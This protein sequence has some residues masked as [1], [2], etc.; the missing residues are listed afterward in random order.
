VRKTVL[1]VVVAVLAG[2]GAVGALGGEGA[3]QPDVPIFGRSTR[4]PTAAA[5]TCECPLSPRQPSLNQA[6][7]GMVESASEFIPAPFDPGAALDGNDL[8]D[9]A[10]HATLNDYPNWFV[11]SLSS[12]MDL[13]DVVIRWVD[14]TLYGK[15]FEVWAYQDVGA[16]FAWVRVLQEVNWDPAGSPFYIRRFP[17]PYQRV[18]KLKFVLT[19]AAGQART[20]MRRFAWN[21]LQEFGATPTWSSSFFGAPWDVLAALDGQNDLSD[22]A[23]HYSLNSYPNWFQLTLREKTELRSVQVHWYSSSYY[24]RNFRVLAFRGGAWTTVALET[25]WSPPDASAVYNRVLAAPLADVEALSLVVLEAVGQPRMLLRQ[26]SWNRPL[27]KTVRYNTL[28][29]YVHAEYPVVIKDGTVYKMWYSGLSAVDG[30]WRI[31]YAV[32][33]D[34]VAWQK[35]GIVLDLGAGNAWDSSTVAFPFVV[36][37]V[38]GQYH[39]WYAGAKIGNAYEIGY[40]SSADGIHWIKSSSNPVISLLSLGARL[41]VDPSVVY[42]PGGGSGQFQVWLNVY[43]ATGGGHVYHAT[44]NDGVTW[45]PPVAT[46]AS[47]AVAPYTVDVKRETNG[48]YTMYYAA[49]ADRVDIYRT[50]SADGITWGAS[51]PVLQAPSGDPAQWDSYADYGMSVLNDGGQRRMWFNGVPLAERCDGGVFGAGQIGTAV[52]VNGSWVKHDP[53]PVVRIGSVVGD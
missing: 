5:P 30:R 18:C 43:F 19:N 53:N 51:T 44:S 34:G 9:Y 22:Y 50:T 26:F 23:A 11:V 25:A 29:D 33:T 21:Q 7:S 10:A 48:T 24:G 52:E 36:K 13:H 46:S 8:D 17:S 14:T 27:L 49:G 2:L 28:T 35:Y 3:A 32:S 6:V 12:L 15:D 39:M 42:T 20:L 16:G 38:A 41:I 45:T 1:R 31:H 4:E 37:D 47:P 40:A